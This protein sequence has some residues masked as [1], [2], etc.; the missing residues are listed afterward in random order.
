[1]KLGWLY[2]SIAAL[3]FSLYMVWG[4]PAHSMGQPRGVQSCDRNGNCH[5]CTYV[6]NGTY[7]CR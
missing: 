2:F 6:G 3:L 7:D 5:Y 4:P 1:M